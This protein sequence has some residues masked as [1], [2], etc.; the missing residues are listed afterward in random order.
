MSLMPCFNPG[1]AFDEGV[2]LA[3]TALACTRASHS[4]AAGLAG[5]VQR[6]PPTYQSAGQKRPIMRALMALLLVGAPMTWAKETHHRAEIAL[7][8]R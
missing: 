4:G 8:P 6:C 3:P 7:M 5:V 1:E 2:I